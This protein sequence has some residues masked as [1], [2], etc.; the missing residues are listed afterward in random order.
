MGYFYM[1]L[2]S[3]IFSFGGVLVKTS[4][5]MFNSYTISFLRFF[6]GAISL[7]LI[8]KLNKKKINLNICWPIVI[9]SICKSINYLTENYGLSKGYSFGN[10]I[11]WPVQCIVALIFSILFLKEK[12]SLR[13]VFGAFLCILGIGVISWNGMSLSGFLGS[14]FLFTLLFTTSGLGAAGFTIVQKLLLNKMDIS[15][16]NISMFLIGSIITV[17]PLPFAGK[18]TGAFS[19]P[20]IITMLLLGLATCGGFTLIAKA[21]KTIPLFMVTII[22]SSTVILSLVW[23]VLFFNEPVTKY[24]VI[25]TIIFIFGMLSINL[26]F[27]DN[28]GLK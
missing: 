14:S 22:Q 2:I 16:M 4:S 28:K 12:I 24:V 27:K 1:F 9:G 25:G 5:L 17:V 13:S 11:V 19:V 20:A 23:A 8:L 6:I 15:S 26:K 7:Y 10:I 18:P 21:M 3:I